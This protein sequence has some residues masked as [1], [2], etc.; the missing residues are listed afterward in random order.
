MHLRI[1]WMLNFVDRWMQSFVLQCSMCLLAFEE[2]HDGEKLYP[3]KI[4]KLSRNMHSFWEMAFFQWCCCDCSSY[5][6]KCAK[7]VCMILFFR[8]VFYLFTRMWF[9]LS[10]LHTGIHQARSCW[11]GDLGINVC[12]LEAGIQEIKWWYMNQWEWEW[13]NILLG[14]RIAMLIFWRLPNTWGCAA[15]FVLFFANVFFLLQLGSSWTSAGLQTDF[16]YEF[17]FVFLSGSKS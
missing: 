9:G 4:I 16:F 1:I 10:I 17:F 8:L 15:L 13:T 14:S 7:A 3:E 6:P 11:I 2:S 12:Y 5:G